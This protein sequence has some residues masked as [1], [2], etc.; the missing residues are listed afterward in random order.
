MAGEEPH[1]PAE[2]F[3][4]LDRT[5]P[6]PL[7]YQVSSRLEA[8]TIRGAIPRG[9]RLENEIAIAQRLGLSRPTIRRA[10][11]RSSTKAC[12]CAVEG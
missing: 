7:Y 6:V 2:L 4:D 1:W 3:A 5:G 11:R 8:A 9:A 10:I 12:W